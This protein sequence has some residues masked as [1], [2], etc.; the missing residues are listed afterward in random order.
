MLLNPHVRFRSDGIESPYHG[1]PFSVPGPHCAL[2][3]YLRCQLKLV[4][5]D[6]LLFKRGQTGSNE[7]PVADATRLTEVLRT[8]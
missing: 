6:E 4:G 2:R 3:C 1:H 8:V 5:I 7:S